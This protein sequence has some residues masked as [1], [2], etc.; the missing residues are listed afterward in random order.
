MGGDDC[1][2]VCVLACLMCPYFHRLSRST[3]IGII[4]KKIKHTEARLAEATRRKFVI[5]GF[6][7]FFDVALFW[8]AEVNQTKAA[9][10][11]HRKHLAARINQSMYSICKFK[12]YAVSVYR[13]TR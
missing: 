6:Y 12:I 7:S 10:H 5:S 3:I 8:A 1:A 11:I 4:E 9:E 13:I 2:C